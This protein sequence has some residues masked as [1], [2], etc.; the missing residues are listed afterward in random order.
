VLKLK[1]SAILA[2]SFLLFATG[3]KADS[4]NLSVTGSSTSITAT[5]TGTQSASPGKFY[6]TGLS[7]LV[8]GQSATLLPTSGPGVITTSSVVNGWEAVYDNL[9]NMNLPYF[10]LY[11]LGFKLADG[12]IGNLFSSGG[13]IYGQ[14]GNN[15]PF[16]ESVSV[17]VIAT[18]EPGSLALLGTGLLGLC[19]M[20]FRR[21]QI[22]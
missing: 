22:V 6:I 14:L 11:G 17:R 10:D 8:D 9:L 3:A 2:M 15:P 12:S 13:Y 4:F 21:K 5:L 7:G 19:M 16:L 20:A 1:L 18:P